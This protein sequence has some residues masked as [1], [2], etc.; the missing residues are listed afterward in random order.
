MSKL[1][2]A[3][4]ELLMSENEGAWKTLV[5]EFI[6]ETGR[7]CYASVVS[8]EF[9]NADDKDDLGFVSDDDLEEGFESEVSAVSDEVA[10]AEN[11]LSVDEVYGD[12]DADVTEDPIDELRGD[13]DT[14][15]DDLD[16]FERELEELKAKFMQYDE[17]SEDAGEEESEETSEEESE[18]TSEEGVDLPA[19]E[20]DEEEAK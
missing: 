16:E 13:V 19:V 8:E 4:T 15:R 18:E 14:V 2:Q 12:L 6:V 10:D 11:D 17:E 1:K 5:N 3:Y 9:E 7:A 20:D